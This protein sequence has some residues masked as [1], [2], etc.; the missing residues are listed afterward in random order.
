MASDLNRWTGIGR[1]TRD[2]EL[3][4][5]S[6]GTAFCRFSIACNRN[7]TANGEK[8]EEVSFFNCQAWGRL[9]EIIN[10]YARKGKQVA[11][12]GRLQQRSW[13]D[14]DGKKQY[15]VEIVVENVQFLGGGNGE[16]GAGP[17][18]PQSFGPPS[19][20]VDGDIPF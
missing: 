11:L 2:P 14:K 6:G 1:L 18:E 3:R 16:R 8:R 10:Q 19:E 5:A 17:Q 7:Y 20:A 13:E 4:Q 12:D 9:A 15:A